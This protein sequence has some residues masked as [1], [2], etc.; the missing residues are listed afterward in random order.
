MLKNRR[1]DVDWKVLC[2][3]KRP[4][5]IRNYTH[6]HMQV[7]ENYYFMKCADVGMTNR[8]KFK[9]MIKC[10]IRESQPFLGA[11]KLQWVTYIHFTGSS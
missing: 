8:E 9:R 3:L 2:N 6:T 10:I 1:G 11:S 7:W 5:L 4:Q